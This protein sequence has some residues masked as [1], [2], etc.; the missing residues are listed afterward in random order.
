[1]QATEPEKE[2]SEQDRMSWKQRV[3][4]YF[5][6]IKIANNVI[7]KMVSSSEILCFSILEN[8][9]KIATL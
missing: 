1:M 7:S 5:Q 3:E 2:W 6:T 4:E 9:M 8:S